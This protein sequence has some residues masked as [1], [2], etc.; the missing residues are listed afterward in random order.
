MRGKDIEVPGESGRRVLVVD[1][2]LELA[3]NLAEMLALAGFGAVVAGS[4]EEAFPLALAGGLCF[5]LTDYR[6]PGRS[7]AELIRDLRGRGWKIPAALMS[8]Y[9]DE[10]TIATARA[11]GIVEFIPKPVDFRH[12]AEVIGGGAAA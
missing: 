1:D 2:N 8:A 12:L 6:L 5:V 11:A 4:A 3:D 7:G 9:T 10:S